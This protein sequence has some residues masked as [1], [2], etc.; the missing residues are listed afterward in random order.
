M[1][2]KDLHV[3]LLLKWTLLTTILALSINAFSQT[4]LALLNTTNTST[5]F[6]SGWESLDAVNDN[7]PILSSE[8][9]TYA[10]Y[11]NWNG[12]G[13]YGKYNWVEYSWNFAHT[14]SSVS[15][16]W[17]TD[18]GGLL[19]P[20]DAYIEYWNGLQWVSAGDLPTVADTFNTLENL[21]INASKIRVSMKSDTSTAILEFQVFG[22]E[23]TS[24]D[25]IMIT[26]KIS[27]NSETEEE[28]NYTVIEGTD[29]V[30]LIPELPLGTSGGNMLWSGPDNFSAASQTITLS[31]LSRESSGTYTYTYV[32]GCGSVTTQDFIITVQETT[33]AF[34]E[35]PAYDHETLYYDWSAEYPSFPEPT[36][37]LMIDYPGYSGCN[38]DWRENYGSWTFVAGPTPNPEI[39]PLAV[40]NMLER[41]DADFRFLRDNMGWPPDK[42]H[43]NGYRSMI[44]LLGS[45]L[46][47]DNMGQYDPGGWMGTIGTQDGEV[48]HN[49]ILSYVP[50]KAFDPATPDPYQT[51][52]V[53]HEGIHALYAALP[54]CRDAAWFHEGSNVWLQM[55]LEIEKAGGQLSS[56]EASDLGWLSSPSVFSPFTPI[57]TYGGWLTDGTFAGPAAQG[58]VRSD[59]TLRT[60]NLFGGMQ[61]STIFPTFLGE[62]VNIKSLPW[63]WKYAIGHVLEGI[64]EGSDGAPGLGDFK[65][66]QLIQ[67][68]RARL[69]LSDF[70]RFTKPLKNMYND[71]FQTRIYAE[72]TDTS[73]PEPV[74]DWY[75]T[76][77]AEMTLDNEG[78]LIPNPLTLPGWS[79]ANFIPIHVTG[80][81][82]TVTFEPLGRNMSIQLCYRTKEG[83]TFYSQPVYAGDCT[84]SFDQGAP[85]NGV[86]FA[87]V[88]NTDYVYSEEARTNKFNYKLK[89]GTGAIQAASTDLRWFN[90]E[91]TIV[92]NSLSTNKGVSIL[93][94]FD[95]YP[96]P[97]EK[98]GFF[99]IKFKTETSSNFDVQI[100]NINGQSIY[101]KENCNISEQIS[102]SNLSKG[103]Y[104]VTI[105]TNDYQETKKLIV[106]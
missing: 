31:S 7:N 5:S 54:G 55:V 48:W 92:D 62:I 97:T 47:N 6:V 17:F 89:L 56:Y 68:Y 73:V 1:E 51:G 105:K 30:E 79:G 41:V 45:G 15:V 61:Y 72:H 67:E 27:V 81:S 103:I 20:N 96:N 98:S 82:A 14:I 80:N 93:S 28:I 26:P 95:L 74:D 86:I 13:D 44:Y 34:N 46:C 60:R 33:S 49:V 71:W 83:A 52:A 102:T 37:N 63:V 18:M 69:A 22:T 53:V 11:G 84:I 64:A 12:E 59:G 70:K 10:V 78:Y 77:Y 35:W 2:Q 24:C 88:C 91:E 39:T 65:T 21:D 75:A 87:V 9:R 25:P 90:W 32:N 36:K 100:S 43:Q 85:A 99:N 8:D 106:K 4:N 3:I 40:T 66:R 23:T 104:F 58:L 19:I 50:V 76:P 38:E 57:E 29:T 94:R 16:Y 42:L 101:V